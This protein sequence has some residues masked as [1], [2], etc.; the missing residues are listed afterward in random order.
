M[1][2]SAYDHQVSFHVTRAMHTRLNRL[3][4]DRNVP[5]AEIGREA[6]RA[7]LDE[8]VDVQGSRKHFTKGFQRRI[9]FVE[10]QLTVLLWVLCQS[11][12][13]LLRNNTNQKLTADG[14]LT[15]AIRQAQ[16]RHEWLHQQLTVS[17]LE[18][19]QKDE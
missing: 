15:Q 1:T 2:K 18:L 7:Y 13:Y 4:D 9:D 10:W 16:E 8:Q 5:I 6:L 14:L 12:A 17:V 11:L 19:E 3:A